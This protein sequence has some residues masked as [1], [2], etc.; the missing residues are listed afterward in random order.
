MPRTLQ[1]HNRIEPESA[2]FQKAILIRVGADSTDGGGNWRGPVDTESGRFAYI[3]IPEN[4][5]AFHPGCER[6]FD[7]V[8]DPL[9]DFLSEHS[10]PIG[11]W[12]RRIDAKLG[13]PMHLDP[14]YEHLTYGDVGDVR[15]RDLRDFEPDDLIVFYSGLQ[16]MRDADELVYAVV[17]VFVVDEIVL[18]PTVVDSRR[19]E[20]AHTR[21]KDRAPRDIVVRAHAGQ[22][23][24]TSAICP[25]FIPRSYADSTRSLRFCEC[26]APIRGSF[27][28]PLR[29]RRR[30]PTRLPSNAQPNTRRTALHDQ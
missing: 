8:A 19:G 30:E 28:A 24:N 16:P 17:G 12:R 22:T 9:M 10:A 14:D 1:L 26:G 18:A 4:K 15:G 7:E 25:I 23:R 11:F 6:R 29:G 27:R 2:L 13:Q 3:P 5:V 20:N 21:K